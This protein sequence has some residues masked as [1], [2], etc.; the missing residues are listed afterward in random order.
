METKVLALPT[1]GAALLKTFLTGRE[2]RALRNVYL[3]NADIG[4]AGTAAEIKGIT[5]ALVEEEENLAIKTVVLE[6]N[7]N[8][9]NV[10]EDAL[11]LRDVDYN[12]LLE[13]VREVTQ[14]KG[15]LA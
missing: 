14:N 13:A 3:K 15:F 11:S 10:L 1:G 9:E 7:G 5:G 8:K 6:I 12:A 4:L 2:A